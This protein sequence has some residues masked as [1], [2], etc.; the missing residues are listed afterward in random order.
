MWGPPGSAAWQ[1]NDPTVQAAR[2]ADNNT[3]LW[4]YSGNGNPSEIGEGSVP[5]T[6]IEQVIQQ[7]NIAPGRLRV[8][9]RA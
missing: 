8:C 2:L 5:G 3:R 7:S 9:R 1:R 6:I 4:I